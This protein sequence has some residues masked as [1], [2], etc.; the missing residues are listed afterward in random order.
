MEIVTV[1]KHVFEKHARSE[2]SA[3]K[4]SEQ[5]DDIYHGSPDKEF[6]Q[7]SHEIDINPPSTW[8]KYDT[9][10]E[11]GM[12]KVVEME[13]NELMSAKTSEDKIENV[14]HLSVA[15]LHYWRMLKHE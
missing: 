1:K 3:E 9:S 4:H 14:Y 8:K 10:T 6:M 13:Y 7:K 11:A 15:L 12:K 2:E 5:T